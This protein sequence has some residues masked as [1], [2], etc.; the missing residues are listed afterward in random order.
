MLIDLIL[1]L[2]WFVLAFGVGSVLVYALIKF[3]PK[4]IDFV[5]SFIKWHSNDDEWA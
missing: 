2:A 3:A 4:A 1:T 5:K